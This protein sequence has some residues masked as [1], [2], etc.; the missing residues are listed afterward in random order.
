MTTK[1]MK[2]I[3][4]TANIEKAI[5][6]VHNRGKKYARDCHVLACSCLN[7]YN[8]HGDFTLLVR[9]IDAMPNGWRKNAIRGWILDHSKLDWDT[10]NKTFVHNKG[11]TPKHTFDNAVSVSPEEYRAEADFRPFDF[12]AQLVALVRRAESKL[13]EDGKVIDK[14]N[15]VPTDLLRRVKDRLPVEAASAVAA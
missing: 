3:E 9:F 1:T 8:Q 6:S 7:H 4:G 14:R 10:E 15:T 13:D 5:T 12:Q 2:L 11:K